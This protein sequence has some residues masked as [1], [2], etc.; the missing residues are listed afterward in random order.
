MREIQKLYSTLHEASEK[1]FVDTVNRMIRRKNPP[2]RLQAQ[3]KICGYSQR[4]LAEKSG[5]N[6]RTLQQYELGA[7]DIN[8]ATGGSLLALA[9]TL[10]CRVEDI[11]EYDNSEIDENRI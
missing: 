9:K 1:K 7:K 8:K 3:R 6:L 2:T 5:V 11:L 4:A 10:G